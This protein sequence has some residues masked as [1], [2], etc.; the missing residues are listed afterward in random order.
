MQRALLRC[1]PQAAADL[2]ED[3]LLSL[4]D[5]LAGLLGQLSR[6]IA[7]VSGPLDCRPLL[8]AHLL[9]LGDEL[10]GRQQA[11]G[12][13]AAASLLTGAD[14]LTGAD[15]ATRPAR[16]PLHGDAQRLERPRSN[17]RLLAATG[18][19]PRS[20]SPPGC[21]APP[22]GRRCWSA[23][24]RAKPPRRAPGV[25]LGD[26]RLHWLC[27]V[28]DPVRAR[29]VSERECRLLEHAERIRAVGRRVRPDRR[30]ARGTP[31]GSPRGTTAADGLA[32]HRSSELVAIPRP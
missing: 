3:L 8:G 29:V 16:D 2:L 32:P 21:A 20:T 15:D 24:P 4:L 5:G 22:A 19:A 7:Q 6:P 30:Y 1:E 31:V 12:R 9:D 17:P 18:T 11:R 23:R 13:I 27:N 28:R 14:V 26:E 25:D 10:G